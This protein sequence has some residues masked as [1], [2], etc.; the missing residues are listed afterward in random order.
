TNFNKPNKY[1]FIK[2]PISYKKIFKNYHIH[3]RNQ[4]RKAQKNNLQFR[5][6]NNPDQKIIERC[7]KIYDENMY[8]LNTFS[9]NFDFFKDISTLSF[10]FYIVVEKNNEI[11]SFGLM[12]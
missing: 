4:V 5:T 12:L 7:Y 11:I 3:F 1:F 6:I 2:P 10:S 9:F 8:N